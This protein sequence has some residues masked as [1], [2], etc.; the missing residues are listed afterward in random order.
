MC[1]W[2][3]V[4][5]TTK[6]VWKSFTVESGEL[7]VPMAGVMQTLGLSVISWATLENPPLSAEPSLEE[8]CAHE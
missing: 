8:V 3:V 5:V 7:S 1:G 2:L 6:D 4:A